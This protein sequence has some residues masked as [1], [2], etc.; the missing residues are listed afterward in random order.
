MD[1]VYCLD[2]CIEQENKLLC[3]TAEIMKT[4]WNK[5][6]LKLKKGLLNGNK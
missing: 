2:V 4:I 1:F 6:N 3:N 5:P